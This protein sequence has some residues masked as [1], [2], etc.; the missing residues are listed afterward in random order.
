MWA[1]YEEDGDPEA[2]ARKQA[3]RFCAIFMPSLTS[4][5][6]PVRAGTGGALRS[7]E[8]RLEEGLTRRLTSHPVRTDSLVQTIVL[9]KSH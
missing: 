9:A 1:E 4:A 7:F 8:D 5:I 6:T 3:A 2:L